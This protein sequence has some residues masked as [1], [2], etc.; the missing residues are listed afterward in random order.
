MSDTTFDAE[1]GTFGN[2]ITRHVLLKT[3]ITFCV[4]LTAD[5]SMKP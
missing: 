4:K 5:G 1:I 3:E 2:L